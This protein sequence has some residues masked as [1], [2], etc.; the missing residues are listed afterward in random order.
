[1]EIHVLSLHSA[2]PR[3]I[4]AGNIMLTAAWQVLRTRIHLHVSSKFD[5][6]MYSI[7]NR[8]AIL[9]VSTSIVDVLYKFKA[10]HVFVCMTCFYRY[11]SHAKREYQTILSLL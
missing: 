7:T 5:Q 8:H 1:M 10:L 11:L 3:K 9:A 6:M 2:V 4:A